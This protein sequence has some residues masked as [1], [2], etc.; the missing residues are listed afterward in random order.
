MF[1]ICRPGS[2]N[3]HI[4]AKFYHKEGVVETVS[5]TTNAQIMTGNLN[6]NNE[7]P[8]FV[9]ELVIVIVNPPGKL[10]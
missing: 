9:D 7:L 2:V 5:N 1:F 10:K 3:V 8:T 4:S 6:G